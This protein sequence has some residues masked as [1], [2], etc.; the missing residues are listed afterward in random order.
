LT[1]KDN[2]G[3]G[4]IELFDELASIKEAAKRGGAVDT[5]ERLPKGYETMLGR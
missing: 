5:I 2:I 4:Q 3:L 1:A